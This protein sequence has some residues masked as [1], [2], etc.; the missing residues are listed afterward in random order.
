MWNHEHDLS[1]V[2][3]RMWPKTVIDFDVKFYSNEYC[4]YRGGEDDK[5]DWSR[6]LVGRVSQYPGV[7]GVIQ[8]VD[9]T[10]ICHL[11]HNTIQFIPLQCT[12]SY[13]FTNIK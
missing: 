12:S 9:M 13:N 1:E 3:I 11:L 6:C 7:T 8:W 2:N 4:V 5:Y 10:Y